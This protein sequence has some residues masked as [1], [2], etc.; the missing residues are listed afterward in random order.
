MAKTNDMKNELLKQ[1]ERDFDGHFGESANSAS[2]I[3]GR[4]KSQLRRLK[5][6]AAI[7]WTISLIFAVALHNLKVYVFERDI[8]GVFTEN[9]FWLIRYSDMTLIVLLAIC[10][11]L[12]YLVYA[13]SRTL[14]M[15]QICARLAN[16]EEQ[17]RRISQGE[18]SNPDA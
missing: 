13:K 8:D 5:W 11:L 15:L 4:H 3:I 9:E 18:S 14:T 12:A 1:M 16:I 10:V 17:L 6:I 2:A 7:G